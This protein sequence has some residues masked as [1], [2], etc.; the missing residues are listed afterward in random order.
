MQFEYYD[1]LDVIEADPLAAESQLSSKDFASKYPNLDQRAI[2][3]LKGEAEQKANAYRSDFANDLIISGVSP[4]LDDL[5]A[6]EESGQISKSIH[7]QWANRIRSNVEPPHDPAVYEETFE[8]IMGYNPGSDPSGQ[9]LA[10]LRNRVASLNLPKSD[11]QTLN[12]K[13]NDRLD[14]NNS[15]TP[16]GKQEAAF[17]SRIRSDFQ[18]GDFG[19]FR[20]FADHDNDRLPPQQEVIKPEDWDKAWKMRGEFAEQWRRIY[21]SMPPDASF[22]QI[23]KAYSSLKQSFQ[24]K[25]PKP[26]LNFGKPPALDF[27]PDTTLNLTKPKTFGGLPVK[28]PGGTYT[29]AAATVF[30]GPNDPND[31]G[32]SAFGGKTGDGAKQGTAI[33]QALLESKFPGKDKA[34]LANNVRTVVRTPAGIAQVFPVVDLGTAEWVWQKNQRPTLDLTEGAARSIGGRPVYD[35]QGKLKGLQGLDNIDFAVVSIDIGDN[36]L[37]GLSWE[38]AKRAWFKQ[39]KPRSMESAGNSLI[40]LRDAWHLAQLE[41][42]QVLPPKGW[43]SPE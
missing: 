41:D 1:V 31:N 3:R 30:G 23:D 6:M 35:D 17:A 7:A 18:R 12:A 27:D 33:P 22:D 42:G 43:N 39:N 28:Q 11:V 34:W 2:D 25:K 20:I 38:D 36:D 5:K 37:A 8:Q 24:S 19:K 14:T 9:A 13:L 26:A 10:M 32:K 21:E 16:K 4:S 15:D 29:G 40:A